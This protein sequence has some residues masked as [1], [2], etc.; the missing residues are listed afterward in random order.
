MLQYIREVR[1]I[2]RWEDFGSEWVCAST[3]TAG[4]AWS[5][6]HGLAGINP[7][8]GLLPT[9]SVNV[10]PPLNFTLFYNSLEK[11]NGK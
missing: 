4:K 8:S 10:K 9:L 5:L 11:Q 6:E 2:R 3:D 1:L 7:Y